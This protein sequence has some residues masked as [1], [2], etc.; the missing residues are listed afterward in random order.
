MVGAA[1]EAA[2]WKHNGQHPNT[3]TSEE[4]AGGWHLLR[5]GNTTWG[6]RSA[7]ADDFPEKGWEIADGALTVLETGGAESE[8]GGD[9]ITVEP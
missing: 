7:R 3:L 1:V 6:W 5:D 8:A 4:R 2:V 9:I